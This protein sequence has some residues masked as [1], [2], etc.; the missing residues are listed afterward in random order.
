MF[1]ETICARSALLGSAGPLLLSYRAEERAC[2]HFVAIGN[3]HLNRYF[4]KLYCDTKMCVQCDFSTA[5]TQLKKLVPAITCQPRLKFWRN[6]CFWKGLNVPFPKTQI[7]TKFDLWVKSYGRNEFLELSAC[8]GK[9]T[10]HAH[11]RVTVNSTK[12][13]IEVAVTTPPPPL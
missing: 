7:S 3:R 4:C 8:S 6:L 2:A 10:L 11:F 9:I 13:P 5:R 1:S 12:F